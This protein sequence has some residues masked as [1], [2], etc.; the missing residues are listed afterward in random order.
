M[1]W[2]LV[3]L[4][5]LSSLIGPSPDRVHLS[6]INKD[7]TTTMKPTPTHAQLNAIAAAIGAQWQG[8]TLCVAD[9]AHVLEAASFEGFDVSGNLQ[10]INAKL[11]QD[12][13]PIELVPL[14]DQEAL[15][16]DLDR[17]LPEGGHRAWFDNQRRLVQ[18]ALAEI[19]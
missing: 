7:D 9:W 10:R 14:A 8:V 1:Y 19:R 18:Q 3:M 16:D 11:P 17:C 4:S 13:P 5:L 6:V 15:C 12:I 2:R